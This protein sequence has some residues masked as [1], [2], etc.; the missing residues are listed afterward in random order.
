[1]KRKLSDQEREHLDHLV[2]EAE[3]RSGAQIVLAFIQRSDS[4]AELPWKAFALGASVTGLFIFILHL[5]SDSWN[6]GV[7]VITTIVGIFTAGAF[8]ALLTVLIPRFGRLF[9]SDIRAE[10]E[11]LQYA[12]SMFL[13]RELFVTKN[14][15]GILLLVSSFERK[16]VILPDHGLED[17]LSGDILKDIISAMAPFLKKGN[18]A[19]AFAC[20]LEW[21]AQSL[22]K[23]SALDKA[24][25]EL[26]D[27]IIEE[28]GV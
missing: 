24:D 27:G 1:M 25:N 16:I 4:Y 17:Q 5:L 7:T 23:M 8:F 10:V 2:K 22:D 18:I 13:S 28:K 12:Q 21:L 3:E 9:L 11:V 20:G 14:R 19:Q 6:S 26:D 15:V